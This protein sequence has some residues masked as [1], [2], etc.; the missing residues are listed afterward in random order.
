M[1]PVGR[2]F[3][4]FNTDVNVPISDNQ[5]GELNESINK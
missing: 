5:K 1:K 3:S 4:G 2:N